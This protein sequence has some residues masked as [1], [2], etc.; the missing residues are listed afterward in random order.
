VLI[1]RRYWGAVFEGW[2]VSNGK[3][4]Y[5]V[6]IQ[7]MKRAKS[8]RGI[9]LAGVLL[10]GVA[11]TGC[12]QKWASFQYEM[13]EFHTKLRAANFEYVQFGVVGQASIPVTLDRMKTSNEIGLVNTALR[14]IYEGLPPG[15]PLALV[16]IV[17]DVSQKITTESSALTQNSSLSHDL[18]VIRADVVRFT[19]RLESSSNASRAVASLRRLRELDEL[20]SAGL[21]SETDFER[22]LTELVPAVL[23]A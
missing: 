13:P 21:V 4:E 18:L 9:S 12:G 3:G 22:E 16:N 5:S 23:E 1:L 8:V 2:N 15:Q 10:L 17:M 6:G 7:I 11:V 14:E 20:H 19:G